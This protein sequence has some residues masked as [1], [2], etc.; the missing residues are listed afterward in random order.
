MKKASVPLL[1]SSSAKAQVNSTSPTIKP[2][3]TYTARYEK[4]FEIHKAVYQSELNAIRMLIPK[5]GQA[6]E[7]GVGTGRFSEP[8]G[9]QH[10]IDPARS[11][12]KLSSSKGIEIVNGVGE[13]LPY[14]DNSFDLAL[15]VTTICF[16]ADVNTSL[17][18][19]FRILKPKGSLVVGLVDKDSLLGRLYQKR[20]SES[21]FYSSAHFYGAKQV[22][23]LLGTVGF[24]DLK[25]VQTIF[26][27]LAEI[28]QVEPVRPG[29]GEGSFV[30]VRAR[31]PG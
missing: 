20:R 21:P 14:V 23:R 2:F 31:K 12:L 3:E 1:S 22:S 19:A 17:K 5:F 25:F 10:G 24:E 16:F 11:P 26:K 15:I 9:I 28:G 18:E 6:L 7:I 29:F 4:W 13:A 30:A 27:S 8:F